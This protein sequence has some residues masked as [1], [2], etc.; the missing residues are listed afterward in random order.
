MKKKILSILFILAIL[1]SGLLLRTVVLNIAKTKEV[2]KKLEENN[3]KYEKLKAEKE[4][5]Q[6][7]LE[8]AR[9]GLNQ[10]KFAR[11]KLNMKKEGETI[12][13]IIEDE[14]VQEG[15]NEDEQK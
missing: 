13:K 8:E 10:E 3:K 2:K 4:K 9:K 1:I 15:V 14:E 12:Y 7:E 5:L 11:D 6:K